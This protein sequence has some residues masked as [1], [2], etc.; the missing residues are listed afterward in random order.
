MTEITASEPSI[1]EETPLT[2]PA[3][4]ATVGTANEDLLAELATKDC[5]ADV[6]GRQGRHKE[7]EAL[8]RDGLE[9]RKT[10]LAQS[11][12]DPDMLRTMNNLAGTLT[13][14][15]IVEAEMLFRQV[16]E[17]DVKALGHEHAYTITSMNNVAHNLSEQGKH[18]AAEDMQRR[19]VELSQTLRG[20][21]HP[22]T[23][24]LMDNLRDFL[25]VG[26]KPDEAERMLRA[27]PALHH[28]AIQKQKEPDEKEVALRKA[29]ELC[30]TDVERIPALRN[31]AELFETKGRYDEAEGYFQQLVKLPADVYGS[32]DRDLQSS[33]RSLGV[34]LSR[35]R[36]Y[37]EAEEVLRGLLVVQ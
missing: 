34:V 32:R 6:L 2:A 10:V 37:K 35:Q 14:D 31:L 28:Q 3:A 27:R 26:G 23:L 25:R 29:L 1:S 22:E 15:D 12:E 7:A 21:D 24:D 16:L 4:S 36:K 18:E 9:T 8:L 19:A 33:K 30:H 11:P 5:L 13:R 17:A 20:P